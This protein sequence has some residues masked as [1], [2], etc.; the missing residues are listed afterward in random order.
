MRQDSD[1]EEHWMWL[2]VGMLR[3]APLARQRSESDTESGAAATTTTTKSLKQY[4]NQ[5][6]FSLSFFF[7]FF[8]GRIRSA[9]NGFGV[10]GFTAWPSFAGERSFSFSLKILYF[11]AF[12]DRRVMLRS[13]SVRSAGGMQELWS[14]LQ[15]TQSSQIL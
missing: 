12:P 1:A 5:N 14:P 8:S 4:I 7:F 3:R 13:L 6:L 9:C 11:K 10:G 2:G 15:R